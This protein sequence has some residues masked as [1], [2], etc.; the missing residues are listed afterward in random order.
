[1]AKKNYYGLCG[2]CKYC[3]LGDNYRWAYSNSFMCSRNKR[4]VKADEKPCNR[5]E[6]DRSRTNETIAKYDY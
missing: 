1:M 6:P 4:R 2:S 5:Y 3:E